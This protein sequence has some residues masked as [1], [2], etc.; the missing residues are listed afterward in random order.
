MAEHYRSLLI[1]VLQKQ[2]EDGCLC[3]I[4][5]LWS[6]KH[7]KIAY[8]GITCTFVSGQFKHQTIDLCCA[9][10]DE[11]DKTGASLFLVSQ[12]SFLL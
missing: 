2:A 7:R 1:P 11:N 10:Y 3:I 4:P 12:S 6:D 5:D 9:E 8:I